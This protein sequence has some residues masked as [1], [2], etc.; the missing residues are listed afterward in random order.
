MS[1]LRLYIT[2][3]MTV[4]IGM[5]GLQLGLSSL[6]AA[7]DYRFSFGSWAGLPFLASTWDVAAIVVGG[8]LLWFGLET[9]E[10][11]S[12]TF[13]PTVG[14]LGIAVGYVFFNEG[15]TVP[16]VFGLVAFV[17]MVSTYRAFTPQRQVYIPLQP[18]GG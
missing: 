1:R 5:M 6:L 13:Y 9:A 15:V 17:L 14:L 2:S 3:A 12:W 18:S 7:Y 10:C 11:Q 8:F 4:F 16:F